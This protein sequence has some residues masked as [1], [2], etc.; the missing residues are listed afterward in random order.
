MLKISVACIYINETFLISIFVE[1]SRRC[2]TKLNIPMFYI[3]PKTDKSLT[4]LRVFFSVRGHR[5][6]GSYGNTPAVL[7]QDQPAS[8]SAT[9]SPA[10]T[11]HRSITSPGEL[12]KPWE[13]GSLVDMAN[14]LRSGKAT[15]MM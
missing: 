6:S 14:M 7:T 3:V 8:S 1:T 4:N 5:R 11:V 15:F 10:K 12:C 13:P 2:H 9:S